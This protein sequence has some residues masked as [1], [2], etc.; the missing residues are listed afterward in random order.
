M[1]WKA[2]LARALKDLKAEEARVER[3]LTELRARIASLSGVS[4]AAPRPRAKRKM[5]AKGRAAIA[6]AAKQR[7]AKWRAEK[8]KDA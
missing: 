7:W 3:D 2:S 4:G 1:E 6:R 8:K 5:S